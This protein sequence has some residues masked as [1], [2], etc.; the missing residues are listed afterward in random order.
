MSGTI[1]I[2][3]ANAGIGIATTRHF[4]SKG[5]NVAATSRAGSD[6]ADLKELEKSYVQN[7][8]LLSLDLNTPESVQPVVDAAIHKF[9]RVDILINNAGYG[10][11]GPIELCD[12]DSV[13]KQFETNVFGGRSSCILLFSLTWDLTRST[14]PIRLMKA[15]LPHFHKAGEK[16]KG[17]HIINISSGGAHFGFPLSAL[18]HSSKAAL[19]LLTESMSYELS[20][21]SRP[22]TM[23]SLPRPLHITG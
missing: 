7:L 15:F 13:Q 5:W 21:L 4:L 10:Q 6:N 9:G 8:Y 2:T 18:Y 14:G 23:S 16:D 17:P 11:Y 3:G 12:M 20:S 19:E 1:L 22:I